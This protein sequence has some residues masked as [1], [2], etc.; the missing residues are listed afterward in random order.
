MNT[1][2]AGSNVVNHK[3]TLAE[4]QECYAAC[5]D[6]RQRLYPGAAEIGISPEEFEI[7]QDVSFDEPRRSEVPGAKSHP[8]R[9]E[10]RFY[11]VK[12]EATK[13]WHGIAEDEFSRG[14]LLQGWSKDGVRMEVQ[15]KGAGSSVAGAISNAVCKAFENPALKRLSPAYINMEVTVLSRWVLGADTYAKLP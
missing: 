2:T 8:I 1:H 10:E 7:L 15:A 4:K 6:V 3:P 12:K 5:V 9:H 13:R 11:G 14:T